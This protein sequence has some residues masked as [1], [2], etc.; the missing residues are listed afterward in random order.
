M[1]TYKITSFAY[2]S[3]CTD[4]IDICYSFFP[5]SKQGMWNGINGNCNN[6]NLI[7]KNKNYNHFKRLIGIEMVLC[8]GIIN[9]K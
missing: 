5:I 9:I 6:N 8:D 4:I 2:K 3:V 7:R 1:K